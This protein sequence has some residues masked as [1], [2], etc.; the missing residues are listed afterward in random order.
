MSFKQ[1]EILE[2]KKQGNSFLIE[3]NFSSFS[4]V[5]FVTDPAI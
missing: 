2:P 3:G 5:L 4:P 1:R